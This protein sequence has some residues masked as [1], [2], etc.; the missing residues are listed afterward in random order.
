MSFSLFMELIGPVNVKSNV[1]D[2]YIIES[3]IP[4]NELP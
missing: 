2:L 4:Y 3:R 1:A